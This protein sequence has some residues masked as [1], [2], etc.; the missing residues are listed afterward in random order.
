V[1]LSVAVSV[2]E[3]GTLADLLPRLDA[4]LALLEGVDWFGAGGP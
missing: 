2:A 3:S 4:A 1:L